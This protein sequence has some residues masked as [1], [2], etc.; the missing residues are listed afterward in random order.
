MIK[1]TKESILNSRKM[2]FGFVAVAV[3]AAAA[4]S[5]AATG[6]T[7]WT[8]T[9]ATGPSHWGT[10]DKAN[11]GTCVD[12]T[13]QSPIDIV[14]P[15][16]ADLVNLKFG[17]QKSEAGIF[18]NGHTVEAEPLGTA[19]STVTIDGT[20][21]N[22]A[23]FHFHAPSEHEISGMHYPVEI[24]FVNKSDS[25][26][27]AVVGVFV[28]AGSENTEWKAFTDK[29]NVATADPEATKVEIDWAK[30]LPSNKTTVR[31][32]GSLTTPGCTEGVKWNVM[33]HPI[34][35]SQ[36][37][38]NTFLEAYSGNNRPVQP[39]NGRVVKLDSTLTK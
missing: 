10:I 36:A 29:I 25:G 32:D 27:L 31:Y 26:K 12:G 23:Q 21:Y 5:S 1:M 9:G 4:I 28:K 3:V 13:A 35:M 39:L 6:A 20:A 8:Y 22:F 34:T 2:K 37:Q 11:Y 15:V 33:T 18:N 30:L 17:Y 14:N 19:K 16:R 7:S 24:H 38:I